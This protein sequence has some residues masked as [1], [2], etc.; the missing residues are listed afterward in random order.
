MTTVIGTTTTIA[1]TTTGAITTIAAVTTI[2]RT[3]TMIGMI[4]IVVMIIATTSTTPTDGSQE[5]TKGSTCHK[6]CAKTDGDHPTTTA[7]GLAPHGLTL[8][9]HKSS[10]SDN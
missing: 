6:T 9:G 2:A 1:M 10:T 5:T 3:K 8:H 7:E 4:T